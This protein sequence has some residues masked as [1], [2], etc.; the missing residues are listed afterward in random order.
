MKISNHS[1]SEMK[2]RLS[3]YDPLGVALIVLDLDTDEVLFINNHFKKLYDISGD[4]VHLS[5]S[6][7]FG[8]NSDMINISRP[9]SE[10][11]M[12]ANGSIEWEFFDEDHF[13]LI[14]NTDL[15]AILPAGERVRMS[16]A[17][18]ISSQMIGYGDTE[19]FRRQQDIIALLAHEMSLV[20]NE[21]DSSIDGALQLTGKFLSSDRIMLM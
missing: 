9:T 16:R 4:D 20:Q 15:V 12:L 10:A 13:T 17:V 1:L 11:L 6:Q 14:R 7:I 3:W 19:S 8:D 18:D 5:G 21:A 2:K